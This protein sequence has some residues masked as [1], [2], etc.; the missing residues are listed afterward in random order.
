MAVPGYVRCWNA[1]TRPGAMPAQ[2]R[3]IGR[4]LEKASGGTRYNSTHRSEQSSKWQSRQ[5]AIQDALD[6][7]L[8]IEPRNR[9]LNL[10]LRRTRKMLFQYRLDAKAVR[11]LGWHIRVVIPIDIPFNH[12]VNRYVSTSDH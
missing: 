2:A 11:I 3:L 7:G 9:F 5:R 8:M 10:T 12:P 4:L 6:R 1:A